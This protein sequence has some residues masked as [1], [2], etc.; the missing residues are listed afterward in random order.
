MEDMRAKVSRRLRELRKNAG[1]SQDELARAAGGMSL[2]YVGALERGEMSAG[3]ETLERLARAL[4]VDVVDLLK[5]D[6][7]TRKRNPK[8]TPEER[9]GRLVT[10]LARGAEKDSL[11]KFEKFARLWFD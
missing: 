11:E 2:S 4:G 10:L 9:L 6:S 7:R 1:L 5:T 3:L 8:V